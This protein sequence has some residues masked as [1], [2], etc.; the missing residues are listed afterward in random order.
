M[1]KIEEYI[2]ILHRILFRGEKSMKIEELKN[3]RHIPDEEID[4]DSLVDVSTIDI[5]YDLPPKERMEDVLEKIKNPFVFKIGKYVVK[6]TLSDDTDC[7][8]G[9][10]LDG[11]L[12]L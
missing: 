7:T 12:M 11:L 9:E 6:T 4:R 8:I 3:F 5:R 2:T 10:C 1:C